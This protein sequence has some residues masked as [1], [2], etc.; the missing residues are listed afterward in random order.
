MGRLNEMGN[1]ELVSI[2]YTRIQKTEKKDLHEVWVIC[3]LMIRV[4]DG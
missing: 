4:W 3:I 1:Y 2:K